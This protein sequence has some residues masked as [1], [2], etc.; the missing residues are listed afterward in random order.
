VSGDD[1]RT[2]LDAVEGTDDDAWAR[3]LEYGDALRIKLGV[4]ALVVSVER[5][6]PRLPLPVPGDI[7][8]LID[9]GAAAV[10]LDTT[11]NAVRIMASRMPNL[12][13]RQ[14]RDAKGRTLY[15]LRDVEALAYTL[16]DP[17]EDV[18]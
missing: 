14:G 15:D 6:R 2:F 18:A 4:P 11:P 17:A 9:T 5:R 3:A 10:L 16:S 7:V 8:T 13:P 12:L 1:G